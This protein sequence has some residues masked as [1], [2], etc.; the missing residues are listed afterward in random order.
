MTPGLAATL[1]APLAVALFSGLAH[2]AVSCPV[3]PELWDRPRSGRALLELEPIKPCLIEMTREPSLRL[4]IHHGNRGEA[5]LQADELRSWLAALAIDPARV[6]LVN[7]LQR[8]DEMVLEVA[9]PRP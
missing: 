7:D 6:E 9:G 5:A 2:G 1:L 4:R 3:P 8:S